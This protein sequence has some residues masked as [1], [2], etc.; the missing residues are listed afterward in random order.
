MGS[1]PSQRH[2]AFKILS[3]A[4][5]SIYPFTSTHH[6]VKCSLREVGDK[7][8]SID[9]YLIV[10]TIRLQHPHIAICLREGS[11]GWSWLL[12]VKVSMVALGLCTVPTNSKLWG[13]WLRII[14]TRRFANPYIKA[15][16]LS[17]LIRW[18]LIYSVSIV[19]TS[20]LSSCLDNGTCCLASKLMVQIL[21]LACP[22]PSCTSTSA[23]ARCCWCF[24]VI[25]VKAS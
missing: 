15:C 14:C 16:I 9:W 20:C 1:V 5:A 11:V 7:H 17:V 2:F 6:Q 19:A 8:R 23:W 18:V 13:W 3:I 12:L 10:T 25:G 24:S 4:N 22:R 21:L